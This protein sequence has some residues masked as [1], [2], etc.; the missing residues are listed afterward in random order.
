MPDYRI[1]SHPILD[2]QGEP[3]VAFFWNGREIMARQGEM[4]SSALMASGIKIFG[5]HHRD[6]SAQGLFCANGQCAQCTVLADGLPVKGCMTA[7]KPGMKVSSVDELP[8]LPEALSPPDS[9]PVEEVTVDVLV[10]GG[11]PAG[12]S[13]AAELG[14]LGFAT[15]VVDD[16]NRL[17]GK[18]LL[19]TH[20][21][22]GSILDCHAGTRGFEIAA[23][24]EDKLSEFPSISVWTDSTVVAV[25]GDGVAGVITGGDTYRLVKPKVLLNA[26]GAREKALMFPGNTLPGVYGAGAFQTLVNRDL[27]RCAERIFVVGGGNVGLIAAYHALQAGIEVAALV[28]ALPQCGGYQV[29]EDKIRRLGVPVL[30]GHT[31]IRADGDGLV[32]TVTAAAVDDRF[33][34]LPGT[35]KVFKCDTVLV[36]VGLNR[37]DEFTRQAEKAGL[38]VFS[39]GDAREIAE[40]SSAVFSG[41]IAAGEVAG[42]L[43]GGRMSIPPDWHEKAELLKSHPGTPGT[44][45]YTRYPAEGFT[46]VLHCAQRIPCNPCTSVCDS[47]VIS[48][49]GDGLL[50]PPVITGEK[51]TGCGKC[52]FICPGLAITLVDYRKDPERP[53]VTIPYEVGNSGLTKGA[54]VELTDCSGGVLGR[55]EVLQ[56]KKGKNQRKTL[57]VRVQVP[58]HMAASIAG[59]RVPVETEPVIAVSDAAA[60]PM[61]PETIVCRCERVTAGRISDL[62]REGFRDINQLKAVTRI[63]MGACGGK[64][65]E[66]LIMQVFRQEGVDLDQVTPNQLRPLF[67]ETPVRAFAGIGEE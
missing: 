27:V 64:T 8:A 15:L 6:G 62:I 46:P 54:T 63:C 59:L 40:A 13:A 25:Y 18:L 37:V 51:C 23:I 17:G 61:D 60:T 49:P 56:I 43:E 22:F 39:A 19:Q 66:S 21:F 29:H 38:P 42:V 35:E 33:N 28:E 34:P 14:A 65:C 52:L 58:A 57:G 4:I 55:T 9:G 20:K 24:L 1:Q 45:D 31:V 32:E 47:G 41:K 10:L 3:L 16:K 30:T 11:G 26:A 48:I 7:V 5:H 36:A 53:I 50:E 12:L 44:P 2:P 67:V